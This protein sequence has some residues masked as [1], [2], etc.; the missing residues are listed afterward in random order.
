MTSLVGELLQLTRTEGDPSANALQEVPLD[1]LLRN[2][3]SDCEVEARARECCLV[4]R[5]DCPIVIPGQPE[6]LHRA[7]ENT[8]RN[9]IRHTEGGRRSRSASS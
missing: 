2:I 1:Q 4:L 3:V 5:S 6:L 7:V 8:V 9:A